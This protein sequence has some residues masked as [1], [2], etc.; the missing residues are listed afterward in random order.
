M[1]G[2]VE[3]QL[4][5]SRTDCSWIPYQSPR[6]WAEVSRPCNRVLDVP[7]VTASW[8]L[9]AE[10]LAEAVARQVGVV[11][12]KTELSDQ[13]VQFVFDAASLEAAR[14]SL[15]ISEHEAILAAGYGAQFELGRGVDDELEIVV[16]ARSVA[17]GGL[18]EKVGRYKAKYWLELSEGEVVSGSV[19]YLRPFPAEA[20]G[21]RRYAPFRE[22]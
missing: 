18:S 10:R 6:N 11:P 19:N 16:L 2:W 12:S 7:L 20:R 17:E 22:P 14:I 9:G 8:R 3:R 1:A 15:V 13:L 21:F 4:P 5:T